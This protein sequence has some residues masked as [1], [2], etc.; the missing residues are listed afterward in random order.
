VRATL[1][2]RVSTEAQGNNGYSLRQQEE[3]LREHCQQEGI[4]VVGVFQD[5]SSGADLHRPGLDSLLDHV[6]DGDVDIVLAQDADRIT[7]DPMHRATLAD[8]FGRYETR[9]VALDDW[10]DDSHE[11]ELLKYMK[12]WVSKGE[13]L[14]IAE[15][16]RR[17]RLRKAQEGKIPGSG[18]PPLGFRYEDGY[19]HVVEEKMSLVREIFQRVADG[20]SL[21]EVV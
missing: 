2:T 3:A 6:A 7:R 1:Y 5:Q 20:Q 19:Y 18:V 13:R 21:N 11:G 9:L 15:R 17:G 4:E 12:G 16:T 14:K 10:G 8:E